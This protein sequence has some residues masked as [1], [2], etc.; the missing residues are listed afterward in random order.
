M[1]CPHCNH[2]LPFVGYKFKAKDGT[3]EQV[4][5]LSQGKATIRKLIGGILCGGEFVYPENRIE[6]LLWVELKE[7]IS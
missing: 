4:I 6:E 2:T 7:K 3:V 1:K 5:K